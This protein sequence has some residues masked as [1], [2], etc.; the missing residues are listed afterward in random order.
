MLTTSFV[1]GSPNW[2]DVSS[3]DTAATTR[4]YTGLFGWRELPAGPDA[5]GYVFYQ[6]DGRTVAAGG[7]VADGGTPS[8]TMYF[9]TSDV[10]VSAKAV[11]QA[12]GAILTEPYD[13]MT[14]GRMAL[15]ADPGGA[16]FALWQPGDVPGVGVVNDAGALRWVELHTADTGRARSFYQSV[17]GWNYQDMPI[18]DVIYAVASTGGEQDM[19]GGITPLEGAEAISWRPYF[20]SADAD[21]T[22]ARA[23][24]LGGTV[25][26]P[27]QSMPGI[28]RLATLTDPHGALFSVLTSE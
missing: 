21:A 10:D 6:L 16:T 20:E 22:V 27:A 4:F 9:T 11:T 7:P 2:L 23:V 19:F 13:V 17:L 5:P 12:G 8:W 15:F 25:I 3:P 24:E 14:A 1:P 18:G 28:G 26:R